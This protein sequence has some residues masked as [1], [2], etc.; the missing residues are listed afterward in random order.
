MNSHSRRLAPSTRETAPDDWLPRRPWRRGLAG[1]A[2]AF[3]GLLFVATCNAAAATAAGSSSPYVVTSAQ[4][5]DPSAIRH[6]AATAATQASSTAV[7]VPRGP[8]WWS[9]VRHDGSPLGKT[10]LRPGPN[11]Q[12][13][14]RVIIGKRYMVRGR[15]P[16]RLRDALAGKHLILEAKADTDAA[17]TRVTRFTPDRNGRFNPRIRFPKHLFGKHE[18]RIVRASGSSRSTAQATGTPTDQSTVLPGGTVTAV[19]NSSFT[20]AFVNDTSTDLLFTF[21][22]WPDPTSGQYDNGQFGLS[23]DHTVALTF[24]N[25]IQNVTAIGFYAQRQTCVVYNCSVYYANWDHAPKKKGPA[26]CSTAS[27][28]FVSGGDYTIRVTPQMGTTGFDMF[29]LDA[30]GNVICTGALSTNFSKWMGNH[31]TARWLT[32]FFAADA[33]VNAAA[34]LIAGGIY[35][36]AGDAIAAGIVEY[37]AEVDA[38]NFPEIVVTDADTELMLACIVWDKYIRPAAHADSCVSD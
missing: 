3:S 29:L 21:S 10:R 19:A 20:L 7:T 26:P 28:T 37:W 1:V 24:N 18:Y 2:L 16:V 8:K 23:Q 22:A 30:N 13:L 15:V 17:W 38:I 32:I 6:E 12:P 36:I 14:F 31:P 25:P 35:A 5:G 11:A 27:P 9:I 34:A 4:R 33:A